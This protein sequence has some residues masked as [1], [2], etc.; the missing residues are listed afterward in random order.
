[1]RHP[2]KASIRKWATFLWETLL[3]QLFGSVS[4]VW[5]RSPLK[6][7]RVILLDLIGEVRRFRTEKIEFMVPK[8]SPKIRKSWI[9]IFCKLTHVDTP[10]WNLQHFQIEFFLLCFSN[11]QN[12]M[13]YGLQWDACSQIYTIP[14]SIHICIK[15][16]KLM[17]SKMLSNSLRYLRDNESS[18]CCRIFN[19]F[20]FLFCNRISTMN[21]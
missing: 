16:T 8:M 12:S 9:G 21:M 13:Q 7:S 10:N 6:V 18:N 11:W 17:S 20:S 4:I 3:G 14:Q 19:K 15:L 2:Q 1:M 5:A